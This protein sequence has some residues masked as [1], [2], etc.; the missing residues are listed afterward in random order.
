M[1]EKR[2]ITINPDFLKLSSGGTRKKTPKTDGTKIK[3]K[4]RRSKKTR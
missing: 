1:S 2:T 3:V 4:K